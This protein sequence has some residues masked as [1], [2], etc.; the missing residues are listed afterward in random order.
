VV[1]GVIPCVLKAFYW[2]RCRIVN[3]SRTEK[4]AF[5]L[6]HTLHRYVIMFF[7]TESVLTLVM[8]TTF[9]QK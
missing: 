3:G 7:K 6:I 8:I 4:R 5:V 2:L 1:G 9:T